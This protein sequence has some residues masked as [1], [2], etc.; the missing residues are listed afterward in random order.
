[1]VSKSL[2]LIQPQQ[3]VLDKVSEA[4]LA[5]VIKVPS[6]REAPA[7]APLAQ[8][9]SAAI[10]RSA[11]R[12]AS[13]LASSMALPPGVF[14][15]LTFLPEIVGVWKIQAQMVADIAAVHDQ[16]ATLRREQM[17]YCLFKHVSAQLV[18]DVVVRAGE[19]FLVQKA[20]SAA[21]QS[22]AQKLGVKVTQGLVGKGVSRFV[23]V[24]GAL[25]VGAYAYFDTTRVAQTAVE[26]F[27]QGAVVVDESHRQAPESGPN[28]KPKAQP[29]AKTVKA[30][31]PSRTRARTSS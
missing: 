12:K 24:L 28:R 16:S 1:M 10:A 9:R 29:A 17:L 4:I 8:A 21:L 19:R 25:G 26:L 6:S 2:A 22:I 13:L 18:R 5:L 30:K 31:A 7:N 3:L 11:S 15:W 20:S 23:P 14:G 27:S